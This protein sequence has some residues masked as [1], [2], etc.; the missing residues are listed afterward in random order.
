MKTDHSEIEIDVPRDRNSEFEPQLVKK[1][2]NHFSGFDEKVLYLY[3]KGV[4]IRSIQ[5]E[6]KEIYGIDVSPT[7]ISNVTDRVLEDVKKW[8]NRPLQPCY[9]IMYFVMH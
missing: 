3:S 1:R 9:M 4:S 7:L 8:Q 2:Q 6:L 5:G